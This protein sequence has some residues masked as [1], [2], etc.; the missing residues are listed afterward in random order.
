[1][2]EYIPGCDYCNKG[3][4]LDCTRVNEIGIYSF[5]TGNELTTVLDFGKYEQEIK[6][7]IDYCPICDTE[8][9][10]LPDEEMEEEE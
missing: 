9:H 5:I 10:E 6:R 3:K 7:K 2:G 8:L 1:M 4:Q